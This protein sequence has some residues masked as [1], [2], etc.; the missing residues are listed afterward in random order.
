MSDLGDDRGPQPDLEAFT[1]LDDAVRHAVNRLEA[2]RTRVQ[3][4]QAREADMRGLLGQITAG[5]VDPAEIMSHVRMLEEENEV[6]RRRLRDGREAVER[7]LA[8]IRF[9]EEQG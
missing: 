1:R 5:E 6:L 9:L 8:R 3:E 7:L 2:L 4:V